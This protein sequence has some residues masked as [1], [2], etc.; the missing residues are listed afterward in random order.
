[1]ESPIPADMTGCSCFVSPDYTT[2]ILHKDNRT[3]VYGEQNFQRNLGELKAMNKH[4]L[5]YQRDYCTLSVFKLDEYCVLKE[6]SFATVFA[7][8]CH[9]TSLQFALLFA[10]PE[11]HILDHEG[12][13]FLRLRKTH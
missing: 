2:I 10:G 11:L 12:K 4:L 7:V 6:L 5:L 13:A 3:C 1:M 8:T 9:P